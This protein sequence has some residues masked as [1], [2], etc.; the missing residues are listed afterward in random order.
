[1]EEVL[2]GPLEWEEQDH[3]EVVQM[4]VHEEEARLE[5][6]Q[7]SVA[8]TMWVVVLDCAEM[9]GCQEASMESLMITNPLEAVFRE[10]WLRDYP[11]L[12]A[13]ALDLRV[14]EVVVA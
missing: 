6:P 8:G 13:M 3:L 7:A 14:S 2:L 10:G 9:Q 4:V 11:E 1:M 5:V 12:Q